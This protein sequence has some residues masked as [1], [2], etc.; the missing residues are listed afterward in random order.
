MSISEW[1]S[2]AGDSHFEYITGDANNGAYSCVWQSEAIPVV[3]YS[4][5]QLS[6]YGDSEQNG[7]NVWTAVLSSPNGLLNG[8]ATVSLPLTGG[9]LAFDF[10]PNLGETEAVFVINLSYGF[11]NKS[12]FLDDVVL[13]GVFSCP[14][15]DADGICDADDN[16]GD[17]AACNYQ[18]PA[19]GLCLYDDACGVCG[20]SGTDADEDGIC[21]D[22]DDCVGAYDALNVCNGSCLADADGDGI[23]DDVDP[24][25]GVIDAVGV[26]NGSCAED[27]DEDGVCDDVDPCI[28][29]YDACGV[30]NGSGPSGECGCDPIAPGDC[31]CNGNV[32]D[33]IGVCGGSCTA[34]VDGDGLCDDAD[35]CTDTS[36]CNYDDV[37]TNGACETLD[38]CGI[39]GGVGTDVDADGICDDAD[40]CTDTGACNYNDVANETC[41]VLDACGV[42]GGAGIP[43]GDC[44]C[45][46][47]QLDAC[48]VCGGPGIP[49][50]DCD[51]NG[52]QLDVIGVCGGTCTED[53]DADGVCDD[54][55]PCVGVYDACGVCNG[56]GVTWSMVTNPLPGWTQQVFT[57]EATAVDTVGLVDI[58][59]VATGGNPSN[60]WASDV[61]V[62]IVDPNG[63]GV[64]WGGYNVFSYGLGYT[65][66]QDWPVS[67]NEGAAAGSPWTITVDVSAGNLFGTG[68]W[69]V[70]VANG[71]DIGN[72]DMVYDMDMSFVD[73][74]EVGA[75]CTDSAAC[76]YDSEA[77]VDDGTC[78]FNPIGDC[79]CATT[80][81]SAESLVGGASGVPV[82]FNGSGSLG[83]VEVDLAFTGNNSTWAS[84]LMFTLTSP[85]GD[86]IQVGGFNVNSSCASAAGGASWPLNWRQ[87]Y[88]GNY[89]ASLDLSDAALYG[90]GDW[91]L[92]VWNGFD[93]STEVTFDA[94]FNFIG[95]CAD[96]AIV[97]C[98]DAGACNYN[99][100]AAVDDGSCQSL[101]ACGE[102]GG[103][104]GSCSGCTSP[105]SC[106]YDENAVVDDGSCTPVIDPVVGCCSYT[107]E[108][109]VDLAGTQYEV[110]NVEASAIGGIGL[111]TLTVDFAPTGS[112]RNWVSDILISF[113]DPNGNCYYFGGNPWTE[114]GNLSPYMSSNGCTSLGP[115]W[116]ESWN[117]SVPGTYSATVDLT[118]APMSG[119]GMWEVGIHN[120]DINTSPAEYSFISWTAEG[121]CFVEGCTVEAAC[122][123]TPNWT[124]PADS[125]CV[126]PQL[127]EECN[128]DGSV[129]LLDADGDGICDSDEVLR[130]RRCGRCVQLRC[131]GYGRGRQLLLTA[132]VAGDNFTSDNLAGYGLEIDTVATD[133]G[134]VSDGLGNTI[135]LSG[136]NTYRLYVTMANADDFMNAVSGD[137]NIPTHLS[138]TTSFYQHGLHN[139]TPDGINPLFFAAYPSLQYDSWVTI[140]IDGP[141]GAGEGTV[142]T[143]ESAGQPWTQTFD[144][145]D[146]IPGASIVMNDVVGGIWFAL[147]GDANGV[148]GDDLRVLI[149]QLTTDGDLSGDLYCQ[150]LEHGDGPNGTLSP[151]FSF[152]PPNAC[153]CADSTACN[154]DAAAEYDDGS[155][156]YPD[157]CG[158]CDGPG[159]IYECGC[160]DIPEG[161]CDCNGNVLDECGVCGGDGI[162]EGDCDCNGNVLDECGVCGGDGIPEGDCDCNGNA[163]DACGVC[164]GTGVDVDAD[165]ICDDI[166]NCTDTTSMSYADEGNID[167]LYFGCTNPTA[168]NY[169]PDPSVVGCEMGVDQCCIWYGCTDGTF[170]DGT[171]PACNYDPQANSDDGSCEYSCLGCTNTE[172]CNYDPLASIN[173]EADCDYSC[174]GCM[175]PTAWNYDSEATY[176]N[177]SC[178]YMGCLDEAACNYDE[179]ATL[180]DDCDYSCY[181]CMDPC[182][183]NFDSNATI[184]DGL[185]A[186]TFGCTDS[187][188]CLNYNPCAS[189]D[190]GTC[191]YFDECG[192]CGG[193][194]I[195]EGECDCAGTLIDEC[196]DCGGFDFNG[197]GICDYPPGCMQVG[198]CNYDP[199][200]NFDDGSCDFCTCDTTLVLPD[201]A[202]LTVGT[203]D[204]TTG[205][206]ALAGDIG[207]AYPDVVLTDPAGCFD[208]RVGTDECGTLS[209]VSVL[210]PGTQEV[211]VS[212]IFNG[213]TVTTTSTLTVVEPEVVSVCH[214]RAACNYNQAPPCHYPGEQGDCA[215]P[216]DGY[217][218]FL[219]LNN[220]GSDCICDSMPG[221]EVWYESFGS[222]GA[223]YEQSTLSGQLDLDEDEL[224][225]AGYG[226]DG[227]TGTN[228]VGPDNA[229]WSL[230]VNSADFVGANPT[231]W[232][233]D[234]DGG[235]AYFSGFE[236]NGSELGW[237]SRI[238]SMPDAT[239]VFGKLSL[240][241]KVKGLGTGVSDQLHFNVLSGG[242]VSEGSVISGDSLTSEWSESLS[243]F[244]DAP[245]SLQ[246]E[247]RAVS[248]MGSDTD[249]AV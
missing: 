28:G 36:A 60:N 150:I 145:G 204:G 120:G 206:F 81:S 225:D 37:V 31:D 188:A 159:A 171:P 94:S 98:T 8:A 39:C 50:G 183:S 236:L 66:I 63:N 92:Q 211:E 220:S 42:C 112:M 57:F 131:A 9:V 191:Q 216:S 246:L 242:A 158:I 82:V 156:Y 162:P 233:V 213:D 169:D 124:V 11:K 129:T 128:L 10:V 154:Y 184:D 102:C 93:S 15:A 83:Y 76:N 22:V 196:G 199:N 46:G 146:G 19:N 217:A 166:D 137:A 228:D 27:L 1:A 226:Y 190:N 240:Q 248:T 20:G 73:M 32:E 6:V 181:G 12:Y 54:V 64:Q 88:S 172:A 16:C 48:D 249:V 212:V 78:A 77:V 234:V 115:S 91:T 232:G 18:D 198:A 125:I 67:W 59:L 227:A 97:G 202:D 68:T 38:A 176:D 89:S 71:S 111:F 219:K 107:L 177:G 180:P 215:D 135:D 170:G 41:Q 101:D 155:C 85:A 164:G 133:I 194:G 221:T 33:A 132:P 151:T 105:A 175:D 237:V 231:F 230:D 87:V 144:P 163:L 127:C 45:N 149:A 21:D 238:I 201:A 160:T 52:N 4:G 165:G 235:N 80:V 147:T 241:S 141:P 153:G 58:T 207:D 2:P 244:V 178:V 130:V 148:A 197:N 84:D 100:D 205:G 44:D 168:D 210:T 157:V 106:N 208:Y 14:D 118:G 187:L 30:C 224:L 103:D 75:G 104:G 79:S 203:L 61:L 29:E 117:T 51:C 123:Y 96:G 55:D 136:Y 113:I 110:W 69:T 182:A 56:D 72:A 13:T 49:V 126:Y 195:P 139:V 142:S 122:N 167:C 218:Y 34:D 200:A 62:A 23:C 189:I 24:C 140:G 25:V 174:H 121:M 229:E 26:C 43:A 134:W 192:V 222:D 116:P 7:G 95:I 185:C 90:D 35:N 119:S 239:G 138:T 243:S 143:M 108:S 245:E 3:D 209:S 86:C 109:E 161:D 65:D 247:M 5:L 47:N 193:E 179:V 99:A 17:T 74:C 53:A 152:V 70:R 114:E 40:N 186:P 173:I 214:D 223:A